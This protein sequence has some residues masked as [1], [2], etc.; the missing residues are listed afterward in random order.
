LLFWSITPTA[1]SSAALAFAYTLED[2]VILIGK[3][4]EH[5]S[6]QLNVTIR[7]PTLTTIHESPN[8]GSVETCSD[9]FYA[10][11]LGEQFQSEVEKEANFCDARASTHAAITLPVTYELLDQPAG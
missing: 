7:S 8:L 11:T 3:M 2:Q 6:A 1:L 4:T 10:D 9:T 5:R